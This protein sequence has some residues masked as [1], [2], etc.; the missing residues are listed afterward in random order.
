MK[1]VSRRSKERAKK[2][3][4]LM[5]SV[6]AS[7]FMAEIALRLFWPHSLFGAGEQLKQMLHYREEDGRLTIDSQFGFRPTLGNRYYSEYGTLIPGYST[8]MR[9]DSTRLL[10]IGDSV[11]QRGRIVRALRKLYGT[12]KFEYWNAGVGSFNTAQEVKFYTMYNSAIKPNHVIL[13]FHPN[14]FETTPVAFY[15]EGRLVAYAPSQPL[16]GLSPWLFRRSH[17]YRLAVGLSLSRREGRTAIED[18]VRASLRELRDRLDRD[19]IAFSVIVHPYLL[20]FSRW[21]GDMKRHRALMLEILTDLGIRHFDLLATSDEA[22]REGVQV[23][24]SPGDPWHPS[25]AAATRFA[26]YLYERGLV[27]EPGEG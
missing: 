14:D 15:H 4:L 17:L 7:L 19:G 21:S 16:R 5:L 6:G 10:F 9:P 24:A 22:I 27:Q 11:T 1:R 13:T 12:E 3:L 25:D 2:L 20:H 23:Q 26:R 18:E 8:E